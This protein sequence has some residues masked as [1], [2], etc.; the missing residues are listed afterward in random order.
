MMEQPV[1]YFLRFILDFLC[2]FC[3]WWVLSCASSCFK[4][5]LPFIRF[6]FLQC[7]SSCCTHVF[8]K[9][10]SLAL[11]LLWYFE[12]SHA[13]IFG[14]FI[15]LAVMC[16][17]LSY[18]LF[19]PSVGDSCPAGLFFKE[20]DLGSKGLAMD[21][22]VGNQTKNAFLH[23]E[24]C[25]WMERSHIFSNFCLDLILKFDLASFLP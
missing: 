25:N 23:F 9:P 12:S 5:A 6:K 8:D 1:V 18:F 7:S 14:P 10:M 22:Y 13:C 11:S 20:I 19:H 17:T 4:W 3:F 21:I 16:L 2:H 15:L 24:S